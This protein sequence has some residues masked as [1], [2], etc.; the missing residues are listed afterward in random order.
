MIFG[1]ERERR[2]RTRSDWR[3]GWNLFRF[4]TIERRIIRDYNL[5]LHFISTFTAMNG[6]VGLAAGS[7]C[8]GITA[9]NFASI[10]RGVITR[11]SLIFIFAEVHQSLGRKIISEIDICVACS[12]RCTRGRIASGW[13]SECAH[14]CPHWRWRFDRSRCSSL[15]IESAATADDVLHL[16]FYLNAKEAVPTP[17]R[18]LSSRC[19]DL[20]A[21]HIRRA[22]NAWKMVGTN[23]WGYLNARSHLCWRRREIIRCT[24]A[25]TAIETEVAG[26]ATHTH[27][28]D[29]KPAIDKIFNDSLM[30]REWSTRRT[31]E[32]TAPMYVRMHIQKLQ[33]VPVQSCTSK[34]SKIWS[35]N[36][37]W[38]NTKSSQ[39]LN[40]H[41]LASSESSQTNERQIDANACSR[42]WVRVDAGRLC[43]TRS[44]TAHEPKTE[45]E[46]EFKCRVC[47]RSPAQLQEVDVNWQR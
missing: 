20:F 32:R 44:P 24:A 29:D 16:N 36:S 11:C 7:E 17:G 22:P 33:F 40:L 37:E 13:D 46:T 18:S 15:A 14:D 25:A 47:R 1:R 38:C 39:T 42:V 28:S 27:S 10:V 41:Y 12:E 19:G 31:M 8:D 23:K 35:Q 5:S 26:A 4:S 6:C 30:G 45:R 21:V 43:C 3:Y 34:S 9:S 2:E